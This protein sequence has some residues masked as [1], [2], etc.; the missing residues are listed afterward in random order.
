MGTGR[1][2]LNSNVAFTSS[3]AKIRFGKENEKARYL[4]SPLAV[5][6]TPPFFFL[7]GVALPA[8]PLA[9]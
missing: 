6:Y 4:P 9:T 1:G 3:K 7:S 5:V 2:L 8:L